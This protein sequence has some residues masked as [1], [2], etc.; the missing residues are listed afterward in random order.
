MSRYWNSIAKEIIR[1]ARKEF[2]EAKQAGIEPRKRYLVVEDLIK[3]E[4]VNHPVAA[5]L[6][7]EEVDREWKKQ[8]EERDTGRNWRRN[9]RRGWT[10]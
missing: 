1:K 9:R 7:E 3:A 2:V 4:G 6:L 8:I 5:K 10:R